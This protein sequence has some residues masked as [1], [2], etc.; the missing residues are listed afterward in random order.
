MLR[1]RMRLRDKLS[2]LSTESICHPDQVMVALLWLES[3]LLH[4]IDEV[5]VSSAFMGAYTKF[6]GISIFLNSITHTNGFPCQLSIP[7]ILHHRDWNEA[8]DDKHSTP[9]ESLSPFE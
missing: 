3:F 8:I 5:L 2:N 1:F 7:F 4:A 9:S 6:Y